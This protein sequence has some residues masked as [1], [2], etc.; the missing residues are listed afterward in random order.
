MFEFDRN[1][2]YAI[3]I[4]LTTCYG[5]YSLKHESMFDE[6]G[7]FKTFG[8]HKNE[9]VFPFWLV[10]TIIGLISYYIMILRGNSGDNDFYL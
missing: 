8:L 10:T 4:Y 1:L 7:N 5:L 9:T 2:V 3:G 6:N